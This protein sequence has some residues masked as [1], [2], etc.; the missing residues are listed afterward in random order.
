V[1]SPVGA[2]LYGPAIA[3]YRRHLW[4]ACTFLPFFL[5][6]FRLKSVE[7]AKEV[8]NLDELASSCAENT[9]SG[10]ARKCKSFIQTMA[11]LGLIG[12]ALQEAR[13]D[14]KQY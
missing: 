9:L 11:R 12:I 6:H 14:E 4:F 7:N 13:H 5:E 3:L 2:V 1:A 10:I 8:R